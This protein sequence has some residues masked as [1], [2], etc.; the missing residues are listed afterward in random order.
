MHVTQQ[1]WA[2][3]LLVAI[4]RRSQPATRLS[5]GQQIAP[6]TELRNNKLATFPR[7]TPRAEPQRSAT[8]GG[9]CGGKIQSLRPGCCCREPSQQHISVLFMLRLEADVGFY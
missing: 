2:T 8:G 7:N 1:R 5:P 3:H 9:G 6:P 4:L